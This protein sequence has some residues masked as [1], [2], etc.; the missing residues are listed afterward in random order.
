[1]KTPVPALKALISDQDVLVVLQKL[2]DI[3]KLTKLFAEKFSGRLSRKDTESWTEEKFR[4]Y[5]KSAVQE[6]FQAMP[7]ELIDYPSM[8]SSLLE[9]WSLV[10]KHPRCKFV[11]RFA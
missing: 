8:I 1:M 11:I 2:P 7:G 4:T 9:A 5:V 6:K 10:L 3:I